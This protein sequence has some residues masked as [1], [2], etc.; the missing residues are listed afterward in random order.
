LKDK[1]KKS[2]NLNINFNNN[3]WGDKLKTEGN[4][5]RRLMTEESESF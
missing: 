1:N 3:N 4:E 5:N 2:F